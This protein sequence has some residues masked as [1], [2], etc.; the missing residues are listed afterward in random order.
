MQLWF[1]YH[2]QN[3]Q[4]RKYLKTSSFFNRMLI[5]MQETT[6]YIK[7]NLNPIKTLH[8]SDNI[9]INTN[10]IKLPALNKLLHK[11]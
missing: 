8:S 10:L 11:K 3:K 7:K 4:I 1:L 2:L 5:F 9:L 6:T